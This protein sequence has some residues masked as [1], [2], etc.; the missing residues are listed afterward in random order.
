VE[1]GAVKTKCLPYEFWVNLIKK[2]EPFTFTR[3]GDGE[4]NAIFWV[5]RKKGGGRTRNGDG[6]S[7]RIKI[8][9]R[10][11]IKSIQ[12]PGLTPNYYRSLWM[13][14][15]CRP[16][17]RLARDHLGSITPP[18]MV[19]YNA[20]AIHFKNIGGQNHAYFKA[21]R[22]LKMPI[23]I[24]GPKHLRGVDK[25]GCFDYHGFVEVPSKNAYHAC[26]RVIEEAL[27]FPAPCFY[28]IHAGPPSPVISWVLWKERGDDCIICDLG[29][30]LDGYSHKRLG[31]PGGGRLT[32]KF[33]KH[34]ATR[35]LLRQNLTGK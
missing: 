6:H 11:L 29:S 9:R 5:S 21:M 12:Q 27:A 31:G 23:I 13:D 8:M 20:L 15:N 32:R 22:N 3:Y 7:L 25:A 24:I 30:I 1:G 35:R 14:G 10:Q 34:R 33:W 18:G 26:E 19:W 17:E 28:S 16:M 2:E 4:L